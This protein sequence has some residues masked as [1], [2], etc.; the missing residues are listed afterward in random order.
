MASVL[1]VDDERSVRRTF[2]LFLREDGHTVWA[3]ADVDSAMAILSENDIDVVVSDI[4]LPRTS[5]ISLLQA[6]TK[7]WPAVRV[8][9]VTGEPTV[10]TAA[11][12][13]RAGA[14]DYLCK[15][16][17]ATAIRRAVTGAARFKALRDRNKRL[18]RELEATNRELEMVTHAVAQ[19][20]GP[21]MSSILS[22]CDD[23]DVADPTEVVIEVRRIRTHATRMSAL[24][25]NLE[26]L[27][28]A[29]RAKL[30]RRLVDLGEIA[31]DLIEAL[32]RRDPDRQV[33][34]LVGRD[35]LANAD[36]KLVRQVLE[37]LL[38]NAWKFTAS[39]PR[40]RIEMGLAND[41]EDRVFAIRDNGVG[42]DDRH[43][44]K[45]FAAFQRLHSQ[46]DYHGTGLGLAIARRIIRRHG[47]RIW[48]E[49]EIDQGS[50]F[51]FSLGRLV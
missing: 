3:A 22:A 19:A 9:M 18:R 49:S 31:T 36:P 35:L 27:A 5:G 15:P 21:P 37:I 39:R 47:G 29:T 43:A 12:A 6:I 40:G 46:S 1:V 8:I 28:G 32:R 25:D 26:R 45:L 38:D 41:G 42:F 20:L 44:D 13:V 23:L 16:I 48:A 24:V 2:S 10:D 50:T 4:I 33:D 30:R 51:F 14:H 34:V 17:S 7:S 11:K